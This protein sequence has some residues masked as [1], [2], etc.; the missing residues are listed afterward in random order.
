MW[1]KV[2]RAGDKTRNDPLKKEKKNKR[3]VYKKK[4]EWKTT[5]TWPA[6]AALNAENWLIP[7]NLEGRLSLFLW[8]VSVD[9]IFFSSLI[10]CTQLI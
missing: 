9:L 4:K 10:S 2:P 7:A 8:T 3:K 6:V 5:P 1:K